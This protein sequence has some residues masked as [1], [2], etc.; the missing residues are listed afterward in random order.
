MFSDE[1][2]KA[3]PCTARLG[4]P[5]LMLLVYTLGLGPAKGWCNSIAVKTSHLK[6]RVST[7]FIISTHNCRSLP[8]SI[9]KSRPLPT[10][11]DASRVASISSTQT[12]RNTVLAFLRCRV[13]DIH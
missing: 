8:I 7:V 9:H 13:V 1:R 11:S 6:P 3:S 5:P 2:A 10:V 4:M 12:L